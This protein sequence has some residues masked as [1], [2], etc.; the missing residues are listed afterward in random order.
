MEDNEKY[1]VATVGY[2]STQQRKIPLMDFITAY[3]K[4]NRQITIS[5]LINNEGMILS[6]ENYE[7]SGRSSQKMWLTK[8]SVFG[9]FTTFLLYCKVKNINVDTAMQDLTNNEI[10]Y[11][12]SENLEDKGGNK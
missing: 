11:I 5:E 7:S 9:L 8:D 3:Y 12:L 6:V 2:G 10:K 4:D 1:G